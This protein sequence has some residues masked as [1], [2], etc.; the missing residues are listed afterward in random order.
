MTVLFAS[1]FSSRAAEWFCF[2]SLMPFR[3]FKKGHK[4]HSDLCRWCPHSKSCPRPLSRPEPA[5][6]WTPHN[7]RHPAYC[8]VPWTI[9][10]HPQIPLHLS[11]LEVSDLMVPDTTGHPK[12]SQHRIKQMGLILYT[13][14]CNGEK[15]TP[16]VLQ[17]HDLWSHQGTASCLSVVIVCLASS[18][19]GVWPTPTLVSALASSPLSCQPHTARA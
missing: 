8:V 3:S 11:I 7:I 10:Q 1:S 17:E 9:S 18:P 14:M 19:E 5:L 16:T 2:F 12:R 4:E 6:T 13:F 15:L